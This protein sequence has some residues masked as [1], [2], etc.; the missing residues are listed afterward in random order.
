MAVFGQS[1]HGMVYVDDLRQAR[2]VNHAACVMVQRT[3]DAL[4]RLR[5]DDM[6]APV[7]LPELEGKWRELME[8]G[9]LT[10]RWPLTT[11]DDRLVEVDFS[12][13][14]RSKGPLHLIVFVARQIR[15][16][17]PEAA[18]SGSVP[19]T[20]REAQVLKLL[21]LGFTGPEIAERLVL[22]VETV[23]THIRNLK[24][25]LG[26]RTLPHLIAL[27]MSA[28][29]DVGNFEPDGLESA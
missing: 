15:G 25:K 9:S 4:L 17:D 24:R 22:G 1:L 29:P 14:A 18:A 26:A 11:G 21:A 16:S 12:A 10:G 28:S 3:A 27:A 13:V 8:T 2:E 20:E 19:L 6:T 5:I 7:A 23:R